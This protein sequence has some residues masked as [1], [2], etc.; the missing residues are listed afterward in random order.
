MCKS[1]LQPVQVWKQQQQ[2]LCIGFNHLQSLL[3]YSN[4]GVLLQLISF[5]LQSIY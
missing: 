5:V 2:N 3:A 4:P 1:L